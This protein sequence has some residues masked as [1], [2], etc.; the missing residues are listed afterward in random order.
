MPRRWGRPLTEV[1]CPFKVQGR[2][3]RRPWHMND[4]AIVDDAD[5]GDE[6]M[7]HKL[8]ALKI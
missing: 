6:K 7:F 8:E 1:I 2:K 4:D 5:G 3:R